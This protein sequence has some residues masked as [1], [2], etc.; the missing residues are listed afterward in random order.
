MVPGLAVQGKVGV[1][2]EFDGE[3]EFDLAFP[4]R[5]FLPNRIGGRRVKRILGGAAHSPSATAPC[6]IPC[7]AGLL[8]SSA[9]STPAPVTPASHHKIQHQNSPGVRYAHVPVYLNQG[10]SISIPILSK[11]MQGFLLFFS[12]AFSLIRLPRLR[13]YPQPKPSVPSPSFHTHTRSG[14]ETPRSRDAH[15]IHPSMQTIPRK[16][17]VRSV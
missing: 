3:I 15:R 9:S 8:P 14:A 10:C 1:R 11:W 17:T 2:W 5:G 13:H 7:T 16:L 6:S 4:F 12:L